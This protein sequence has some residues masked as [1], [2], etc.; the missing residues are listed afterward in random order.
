MKK[1]EKWIN[2]ITPV[3]TYLMRCNSD[4]TSLLSGTAIKA[5]V[6]YCYDAFISSIYIHLFLTITDYITLLTHQTNTLDLLT[7]QCCTTPECC[8]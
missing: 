8:A 7:H 2:T 6:A 3:L 4:V 5:I 1:G